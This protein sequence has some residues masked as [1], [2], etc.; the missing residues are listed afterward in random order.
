MN[1]RDL[2]LRLRSVFLPG[3]AERDL[4]E[5]I[6]LHIEMQALRNRRL[7]MSDAESL[8][9]AEKQFGSVS[10]FKEQ[11]RDERR[12]N[13]FA[14]LYQDI[15]YAFRNFRRTPGFALT[16][17]ATISLGLGINTA[18]FTIFNA[19]VLRPLAVSDPYSLHEVSLLSRSGGHAFTWPQF[20]QLRAN[21]PALAEMEASQGFQFRIEGHECFTELVTGNYFTMLGVRPALGRLLIPADSETPGQ[22]AVAVVAYTTWRNLFGADPDIVGRRVFMH[23]YPLEVVGVAP[24]GFA[25]LGDA[26]RDFWVPLSLYPHLVDGPDI[27]GP[28]SPGV[29]RVVARLKPGIDK[30]RAQAL[31]RSVAPL[32]TQDKPESERAR[33]LVLESRATHVHIS[34]QALPALMPIVVAFVLI[35]LMACANVANMMLAR[36]LARQREMGI[37]LSLGAARSRLIRQLLTESVLL[38]LPGAIVGFAL[39][40]LVIG[41]GSRAMIAA[42]PAEFLDYV[43][44]VP[45]EPDLRVFG[46]M[47]FAALTSGLIFGLAPALQ[48]TRVGIVQAA[49]GDFGHQF[50]PARLRN[51]LVMVQVTVCSMLLICAGVLLRQ[52]NAVGTLSNGMRTRDVISIELQDPARERILT[53]LERQAPVSRIAASSTLP[54]GGGFPS[55]RIVSSEGRLVLS[56]YDYVSPEFFDVLGV[57]IIRGR[58]FSREESLA[59]APVA[60]VSETLADLLWPGQDA[61]GQS[62]RLQTDSRSRLSI[63]TPFRT[64]VARV[65][66]VARDINIGFA[67]GR[68]NRTLV[69]FPSTSRTAKSVLLLRVSGDPETARQTIDKDLA[70][71]APGAVNE[72]HCMRALAAGRAY[73]FRIAYWVSALLG[74]LAL[75]L[76]LSGVYGVLSYLVEQRTREMGVRM[77]LG[78]TAASLA[79]MVLKQSL[80]LTIYGIAFGVALAAGASRMLAALLPGIGAFDVKAFAGGILLVLAVSVAAAFVPSLRA[81]RIQPVN[82]L[83]HD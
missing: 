41:A 76:T 60:I 83:R 16:V 28:S 26:P 12:I 5:E 68:S 69:F 80:R 22:G 54:L 43:R 15:R 24:E 75:L 70:A 73:P 48:T 14:T 71:I 18:A 21:N 33:F 67:E 56:S 29:L 4:E 59:S 27:F 32:L 55:A 20:R 10:A 35:L 19:Y 49:R 46:F 51:F 8:R 78:A 25:G 37:R 7:G 50:R 23:G 61:I 31:L 62:I 44:I 82:T 77:A 38:A 39:S 52:A 65:I 11:C 2:K 66:G 1:W 17:I 74:A 13:F 34:P 58:N 45:L 47:T 6:R 79:A 53:A 40:Q 57:P 63:Q 30:E 42:L 72:I 36:A 9:N 64:P 81:A 3:R